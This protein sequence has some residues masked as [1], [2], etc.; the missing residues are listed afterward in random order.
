MHPESVTY[1]ALMVLFYSQYNFS[2]IV[3]IFSAHTEVQN[4]KKS[5]NTMQDNVIDTYISTQ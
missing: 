4:V 2:D 3:R 1:L 5:Q